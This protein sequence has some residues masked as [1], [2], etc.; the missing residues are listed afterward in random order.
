MTRTINYLG[1]RFLDADLAGIRRIL[2]EAI[3]SGEY[4][5][6]VTPNVDHVVSY[7]R[8]GDPALVGTYDAARFQICDSRILALLA[9]LSGRRLTPCPGSDLTENLLEAPLAN[10]R[11]IAVIG[12]DRAAFEALKERFPQASLEF[13]DCDRRLRIGSRRWTETLGRACRADWDILLVCLSF[14]KQEFFARD[15]AAAGRRSGLALCVGASVD[16]L[17]GRQVRA[18]KIVQRAGME[19]LHRLLSDPRRMYDRYL[20]RGPAVFALAAQEFVRPRGVA[21]PARFNSGPA[22]PP[23]VLFLSTVLPDRRRTGGEICSMSF[24][25]ALKDNGCNVEVMA[26]RRAGKDAGHPLPRRFSSPRPLVIES[27]EARLRSAWWLLQALVRRR[28][29][30][31]QKYVT[32]EMR[33]AV[34]ARL[35][36]RSWD[37]VVIDHAQSAWL[38]PLVPPRAQVV[39]VAH[40]VE[41]ALYGAQG[42]APERAGIGQRLKAALY[43]R[44]ARLLAATELDAARRSR[45]IWCLSPAD[46]A[47]LRQLGSGSEVRVFDEPGQSFPAQPSAAAPDIDVGLL[48]SWT[49]DANRA[50][51]DWFMREVAPLLPPG[52]RVMVGGKSHHAPGTLTGGVKFVGFV[53][54]AGQFL[55]RCRVVVIPTV[56]GSGVQVKTIETLALG[57]PVVATPQAMRGIGDVP[58]FV[59]VAAEAPQMAAA[60]V[61]ALRDPRPDPALGRRWRA[62]RHAAFREE[63]ADAL[64]EILPFRRR[65]RSRPGARPAPANRAAWAEADLS[66]APPDAAE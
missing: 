9:R 38:L 55:R 64:A 20:V 1:F 56:T 24:I 48:G 50:G 62:R 8:G 41:H 58:P 47:Q 5:Y 37:V 2:S 33:E 63:V 3:D 34:R 30:S 14:P 44:E 54:D 45:E 31:V 49:W 13:V 17:T 21:L 61:G 15:L 10:G 22:R 29:F 66:E 32:R 16:F 36:E 40:N 53:P 18:P 57:L 26:Y 65:L 51:L 6:V 28:P 43:R 39:F 46:A 12:P 42:T 4:G 35:R 19:W 27:A 52:L 59:R 11:R 7:H 60:I 23:N 25:E